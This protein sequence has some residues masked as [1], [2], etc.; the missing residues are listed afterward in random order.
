MEGR[1]IYFYIFGFIIVLSLLII[2]LVRQNVKVK[3]ETSIQSKRIEELL[4][5]QKLIE[6]AHQRQI[7][8]I[9]KLNDD[10]NKISNSIQSIQNKIATDKGDVIKNTIEELKKL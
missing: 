8:S 4:E 2:Y 6:K 3:V 7:D 5:Q 10:N 1:M 9:N